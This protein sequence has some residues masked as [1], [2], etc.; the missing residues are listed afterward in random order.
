M[1]HQAGTTVLLSGPVWYAY[2]SHRLLFWK[3]E[4]QNI[5]PTSHRIQ[6][7]T[8]LKQH[9]AIS[10]T[11]NTCPRTEHRNCLKPVKGTAEFH[12]QTVS[13]SEPYTGLHANT[14]NVRDKYP[15]FKMTSVLEPTIT[16][17]QILQLK[18][19]RFFAFKSIFCSSF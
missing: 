13:F 10:E 12:Q 3:K 19:F 15:T 11:K 14:V 6:R 17:K 8:G 18:C 1:D 9:S 2:R 4:T 5:Q 7:N 16:Q